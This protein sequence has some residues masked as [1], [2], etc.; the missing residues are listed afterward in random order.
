MLVSYEVA[1]TYLPS[2]HQVP[3]L[4]IYILTTS[5]MAGALVGA[6]SQYP[7]RVEFPRWN[8]GS[9]FCKLS[10]LIIMTNTLFGDH[11]GK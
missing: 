2:S 11:R 5:R 8:L 6:G 1:S 9:L 7:T 3:Y 4:P 10:Y